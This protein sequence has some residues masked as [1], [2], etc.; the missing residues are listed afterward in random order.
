MS[1]DPWQD[2]FL[3]YL[4]TEKRSSENTLSNYAL[5]L[6]FF[7]E[8]ASDRFEGWEKCD[9][10]LFRDYLFDLMK[11]EFAR[12]TIRLR[13]SSLRSFYTF[14]RKNGRV[15]ENP[16]KEVELPKIQRSL[17]VVISKQQ[18]IELLEMP[19][20]LPLAK[21]APRWLPYRD[22]A[23]MELFYSS[24]LRR[25][26]LIAL[27][28]ADISG[29]QG[30]IRIVGKGGKERLVPVGNMALEAMH[31]Y[32]Q[33]AK[34]TAGALFISKVGKRLS[35]RAVNDLLKKYLRY[36]SIE[37]NVSAHKLRHSFATHM[38]DAGADLRSVQEMLGHAS[39]ST[40][41]IY[42]HVSKERLKQAYQEAH[43]RA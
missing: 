24:G 15:E 37:L 17:P 31:L 28:V 34:V 43:P 10:D 30:V 41:Q 35:S 9:A 3:E 8:W 18:I 6:R 38:L 14:L 42:T 22:V 5:G 33:K 19:H 13:F 25:S 11:K 7:K 40:T 27:D 36:S 20:K 23:I 12:S 16:L 2:D 1:D 32:R 39:L 4:K 29:D 21:Q 26:E